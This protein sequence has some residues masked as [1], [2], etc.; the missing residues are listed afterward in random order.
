MKKRKWLSI[1]MWA[2]LVL[3]LACIALAAYMAINEYGSPALCPLGGAIIP[4]IV[5]FVILTV[6]Q[7]TKLPAEV[8]ESF[9]GDAVQGA[10]DLK[11]FEA[12][13]NDRIPKKGRAYFRKTAKKYKKRT[14]HS[15]VK[16]IERG[17]WIEDAGDCENLEKFI[18]LYY[19]YQNEAQIEQVCEASIRSLP[20]LDELEKTVLTEI[21]KRAY[22]CF[23]EVCRSKAGLEG[24]GT[25]ILVGRMLK[26]T[27]DGKSAFYKEF[28]ACYQNP[29]VLSNCQRCN[30]PLAGSHVC[31]KCH[32]NNVHK[33]RAAFM[34]DLD[35]VL[36]AISAD[37][38]SKSDLEQASVRIEGR[39]DQFK[40][41]IGQSLDQIVREIRATDDRIGVM[42]EK[43][44]ALTD[45]FLES[46]Q[47]QAA[48]QASVA[49]PTGQVLYDAHTGL[50]VPVEDVIQWAQAGDPTAQYRL[51][52]LY[53]YGKGVKQSYEQAL[54]WYRMAAGHRKADAQFALGN[55]YMDGIGVE[56]DYKEAAYY[57]RSAA[58][59]GHT[60][61]KYCMAKCYEKGMGVMQSY[62]YAVDLYS[63]AAEQGHLASQKALSRCYLH[64]RGVDKDLGKAIKWQ[65]AYRIQKRATNQ[66]NKRNKN[67]KK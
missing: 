13:F 36:G 9:F 52:E 27:P 29:V 48:A 41:E 45:L 18:D 30:A 66:Q 16:D 46:Q 2:A 51:G 54:A 1:F 17:M 37:S 24:I 43:I 11:T 34:K 61:A 62:Q 10:Q 35:P 33:A 7:K 14:R 60:E 53:Y 42:E 8:F 20:V 32:Y 26:D 49:M 38:V 21:W 58:A 22:R 28:W 5:F 6:L 59:Q 3:A 12:L 23:L 19:R 25:A 55:C 56:S 57:Y 65:R 15:L 67:K 39:I 47:E 50:Q 40:N 63:A 4:A 64:G 31:P 44:D